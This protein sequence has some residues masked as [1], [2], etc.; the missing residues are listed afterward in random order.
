MASDYTLDLVAPQP[1]AMT[2]KE[3]FHFCLG[4]KDI[5]IE[6]D[7]NG[8]MLVMPTEGLL[9]SSLQSTIGVFLTIWNIINT[10][11]GKVFDSS[12]G[13]TL[14]DGS[15]RSPDAAWMSNEK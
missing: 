7:E 8:Q 11:S 13:F 12:A 2:G 9:A 14:P 1:E 3:F 4:N 5:Q 10:E 15:I 6:R